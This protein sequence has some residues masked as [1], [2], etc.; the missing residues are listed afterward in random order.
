MSLNTLLTAVFILIATGPPRLL[1]SG[2]LDTALRPDIVYSGDYLIQI[3]AW[4]LAGFAVC[5]SVMHRVSKHGLRF[6]GNLVHGPTKW[7]LLYGVLAVIS[8]TYSAA[9][10]YTLFF[11][12]K[13]IISLLLVSFLLERGRPEVSGM[14][15]VK[16]FGY[17]YVGGFLALVGMYLVDPLLVGMDRGVYRLSGGPLGGFGVEALVTGVFALVYLRYYSRSKVGRFLAMILYAVTWVFVLMSLTRQTILIAALALVLIGVMGRL[18]AKRVSVMMFAVVGFTLVMIFD[19][20]GSAVLSILDH[21]TRGMSGLETLT[22]RTVVA[23][24]LVP[25]WQEAPIFGHG[26]ASG[27]RLA[28]LD[29]AD[30]TGLGIGSAHSSLWK[31]LVEVGIV[32]AGFMMVALV[33]A[34]YQTIRLS[35]LRAASRDVEV[36]SK[37]ALVVMVYA[38]FSVFLN[39]G[40]AEGKLVFVLFI[41]IISSLM[42]RFGLEGV[43]EKQVGQGLRKS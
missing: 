39:D 15:L 23:A 40:F 9:P 25:V 17:V 4:A 7:Y 32:G 8:A 6:P 29:F 20:G 21:A 13:L 14:R 26:F 41:I 28:L 34:W 30:K 38:T 3:I 22:G 24:Y 35:L 1:R 16:V 12:S 36:L 19:F 43:G 27:S 37:L 31:A 2:E 10:T 33:L 11:A 5:L 42:H 18:S